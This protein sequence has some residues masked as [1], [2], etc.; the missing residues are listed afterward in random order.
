MFKDI[1]L[2]KPRVDLTQLLLV[3][4][5]HA[6]NFCLYARHRI[7]QIITSDVAPVLCTTGA[8][9]WTT[10]TVPAILLSHGSVEHRAE[11]GVVDVAGGVP[12]ESLTYRVSST[13]GLAVVHIFNTRSNVQNIICVPGEPFF[14]TDASDGL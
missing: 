4:E 3:A 2:I 8:V 1:S 7:N 14:E 5:L 10:H 12:G 9:I 6:L 11:H 13:A